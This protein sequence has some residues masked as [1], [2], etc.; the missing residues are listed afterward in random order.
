MLFRIEI[1]RTGGM[2]YC[3]ND[4]GED[5]PTEMLASKMNLRKEPSPVRFSTKGTVLKS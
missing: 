3:E 5:F 2:N 1:F 4:F